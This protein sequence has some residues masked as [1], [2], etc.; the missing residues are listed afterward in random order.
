MPTLI[1]KTQSALHYKYSF[2]RHPLN[3]WGKF[4]KS[5]LNDLKALINRLN[6]TKVSKAK[7]VVV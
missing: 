1:L 3:C 6:F 4:Q 5:F 7:V 2:K